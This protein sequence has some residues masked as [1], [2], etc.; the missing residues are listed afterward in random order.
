MPSPHNNCIVLKKWWNK[1]NTRRYSGSNSYISNVM[2]PVSHRHS[3]LDSEEWNYIL[4]E[5]KESGLITNASVKEYLARREVSRI[6]ENKKADGKAV[7]SARNEHKY[8]IHKAIIFQKLNNICRPKKLSK[9]RLSLFDKHETFSYQSSK[10]AAE[11][12]K[13]A[14]ITRHST[15]M[16]IAIEKIPCKRSTNH[17]DWRNSCW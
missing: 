14:I 15:E 13:N 2:V 9:Q 4:K 5:I 3:I 17:S 12:K 11:A 10:N 8:D 7:N 1:L 16:M 6:I